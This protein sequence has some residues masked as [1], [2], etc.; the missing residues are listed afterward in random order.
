MVRLKT[1]A[2]RLF[3]GLFCVLM[4]GLGGCEYLSP[5]EQVYV[6]ATVL[7]L[8][9][10][11]TTK[12][13]VVSRLQRGQE[14]EIVEKGDPWLHVRLD[15][16][17]VGWVHGNYVGDPAA[18]RAAHQKDLAR[19]PRKSKRPTAARRPQPRRPSTSTQTTRK[20]PKTLSID[21]MIAGLPGDL[22]VEEM[23]PLEGQPRHMGAT[24]GGQVVLEFWGP[25]ADLL[26]SEIMVTAVGISD[27]DLDRN[28]EL[29]RTFVRNAV[30]QW[31]RDKAWVVNYIQGLSSKDV[32]K[33]GFDAS[34]KTV[35]FVFIKP[36]GAIRVTIERV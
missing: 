23:D 4:M 2:D 19:S 24:G 9:E 8:R 29:V 7:N 32:G 30:P 1:L 34:G 12:S 15:E 16:E 22:V 18:V 31:K 36:L 28:A 35:R 5:K 11:P 14:L 21:G 10:K 6:T 17:T 27:K 20:S 26:R 33:G 25:E 13:S 3:V